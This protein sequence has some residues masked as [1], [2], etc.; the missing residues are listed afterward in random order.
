MKKLIAIAALVCSLSA[1]AQNK[2]K[3][4][5]VDSTVSVKPVT[6]SLSLN[7]KELRALFEVIDLSTAPHV[8]VEAV[9]KYIIQQY[10]KQVAPKASSK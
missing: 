10:Q 7:E 2:A 8:Q 9:K 3:K 5:T 1:G 6:I 4:I